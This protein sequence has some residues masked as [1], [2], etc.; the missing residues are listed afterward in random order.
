MTIREVSTL[1]PDTPWLEYINKILTPDINQVTE[2]EIIIV[3]VPSFMR[4]MSALLAA[5]PARVQA[6]YLMWRVA[7]STMSYMTED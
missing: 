1:D 5:T 3:D 4:S 2:D 7:G 6:N